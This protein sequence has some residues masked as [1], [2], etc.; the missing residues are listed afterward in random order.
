MQVLSPSSDQTAHAVRHELVEERIGQREGARESCE[1]KSASKT[2]VHLIFQPYEL[3][4]LL[5]SPEIHSQLIRHDVPA[6]L[7]FGVDKESRILFA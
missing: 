1:M 6:P 5:H 7:G 2:L 3:T 4:Q